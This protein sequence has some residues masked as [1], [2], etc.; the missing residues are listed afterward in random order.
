MWSTIPS[1]QHSHDT[2]ILL[3]EACPDE[4]NGKSSLSKVTANSLLTLWRPPSST[5]MPLLAVRGVPA[6]RLL[7]QLESLLGHRNRSLAGLGTW[8]QTPMA[9]TRQGLAADLLPRREGQTSSAQG[10]ALTLTHCPLIHTQASCCGD[11]RG[12]GTHNRGWMTILNYSSWETGC[13]QL[14]IVSLIY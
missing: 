9:A 6:S 7:G 2:D 4:G 5:A 12:A 11:R 14:T 13:S 10:R 3:L 1:K 8:I